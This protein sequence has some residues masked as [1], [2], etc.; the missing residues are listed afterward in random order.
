[1][2]I[3]VFKLKYPMIGPS[4]LI[5]QQLACECE[6][7]WNG[8][9]QKLLWKIQLGPTYTNKVHSVTPNVT[10]TNYNVI[11]VASFGKFYYY[12]FIIIIKLNVQV[13]IINVTRMYDLIITQSSNK[14]Q[15]ISINYF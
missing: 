9:E 4:L 8:T 13:K 1:M 2:I 10:W 14:L 6:P 11:I 3:L 15:N 12:S 5:L 7:V